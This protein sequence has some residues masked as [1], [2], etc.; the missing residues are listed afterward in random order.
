MTNGSI[1][2][3]HDYSIRTIFDIDLKTGFCKKKIEPKEGESLD[4]DF[5]DPLSI[6]KSIPQI[7]KLNEKNNVYIGTFST[8]NV[9]CKVFETKASLNIGNEAQSFVIT[10]YYPTNDFVMDSPNKLPIRIDVRQFS[11]ADLDKQKGYYV[12]LINKFHPNL[13]FARQ[14]IFDISSCMTNYYEYNW[15]LIE[16]TC[17]P[18]QIKNLKNAQ[19]SL[20]DS[21]RKQLAISALRLPKILIDFDDTTVYFTTKLLDVPSIES[22]FDK[23]TEET[24]KDAH[25][26]YLADHEE[27]CAKSCYSNGDCVAY[28]FCSTQV[29]SLLLLKDY[30]LDNK[31]EIPKD[32]IKTIKDNKC[33]V[34]T[35]KYKLKRDDLSSKDI[36]SVMSDLQKK[37]NS[38]DFVL[39]VKLNEDEKI[40][41]K[42]SEIVL[43][44]EPGKFS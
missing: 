39:E 28:S 24:L 42:A 21:F 27:S 3:V 13:D 30:G 17:T 2:S 36:R 38:G 19:L 9:E 34:Q 44:V 26:T 29:C 43:N 10:H 22:Y 8:R 18:D 20:L 5:D 6:L 41:L 15:F 31:K 25:K 32:Y 14:E 1:K 35:R 40:D 23:K 33:S 7:L 16:F 11:N 4:V 37:V 12:F